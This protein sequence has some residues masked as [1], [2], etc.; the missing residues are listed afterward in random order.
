MMMMLAVG[1]CRPC[2]ARARAVVV[3]TMDFQETPL[4][5]V[6][7]VFTMQT[8][9]TVIA[10][11][12]V[13]DVKVTLYM[14]RV[15]ARA[16]LEALC[17]N[18]GLWYKEERDVIRVMKIGDISS[19]LSFEREE[20]VFHYPLKYASCISLAEVITAVY[21]ERI[22]YVA[23]SSVESFN[24]V[25]TDK[26][27]QIGEGAK[28]GGGAAQ[29]AA[30]GAQ[31]ISSRFGGGEADFGGVRATKEDVEKMVKA[32]GT[33][34]PDSMLAR[35]IGRP[36]ATMTVFLRDNSLLLRSVDS[37]LVQ[38]VSQLVR[39][40]DTPTRQV[41]LEMKILEIT[42]G[43]GFE[44]F[45]DL[46]ISPGGVLD[47]GGTV[48]RSRSGVTGI[49]LLNQGA[50]AASTFKLSYLNDW[51]S[52][53]I[54]L[55]EKENRIKKIGSP[56]MV[57]ANNAS[58]KFFQG[59]SSF[60]RKGYDIYTSKDRDGD[61]T[62]EYVKITT[63]D[64]DVGVKLEISPSINM[65]KTVALKIVAEIS[66]LVQGGGPDIPY[67]I[68]GV[69]TLGQTDAVTKTTIQDI[70]VAV[71]GKTLALGGLIE[72][73]DI[74]NSKMVPLLGRI[75]ILGFFFRSKEKLRERKEIVFLVRPHIIESPVETGEVNRRYFEKNSEHPFFTDSTEA[76]FSIENGGAV[77][78]RYG[79]I[80]AGDSR[81]LSETRDATGGHGA[82]DSGIIEPDSLAQIN[83][84]AS[85]RNSS[86]AAGEDIWLVEEPKQTGANTREVRMDATVLAPASAPK[87]ASSDS[88]AG[89]RNPGNSLETKVA[90]FLNDWCAAWGSRDIGRYMAFY[91]SS[92]FGKGRSIAE[93]EEAKRA[94]FEKSMSITVSF[95]DLKLLDS[96]ND[97]LRIEFLQNYKS[98]YY[99]DTAMKQMTLNLQDGNFLILQEDVLPGTEYP[100]PC[101]D[102]PLLDSGQGAMPDGSY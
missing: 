42:L 38:E 21:G 76:L 57:C 94:V 50:L 75:P 53:R 8:G 61:I 37:R 24:H 47:A 35:G 87:T 78:R 1:P 99:C 36:L 89:T 33:I 23:P 4:S 34:D 95:S 98:D 102:G 26:Y 81:I 40:L 54:E 39:K 73:S 30:G 100:A 3:R 11:P 68:K 5:D 12:D 25:G 92:F 20:Q 97:Y 17:K 59:T 15:S 45:V 86:Q 14:E 63:E 72:E 71:D 49:D 66:R 52:S 44:S 91:H 74:D 65:D 16:A 29:A 85:G 41:L 64:V 6:L 32:T 2:Y 55:Y 19:N 27:P 51:L 84:P 83:G 69:S 28:T 9:K 90:G 46:A 56:L 93:W 10:S 88:A 79:Q 77:A 22:T 101:G 13:K 82:G 43:D 60:I 58:G 7:K 48:T 62:D 67:V 70:V 18:H 80:L 31:E 96:R